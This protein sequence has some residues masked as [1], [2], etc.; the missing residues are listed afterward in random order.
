MIDKFA[1][2]LKINWLFGISFRFLLALHNHYQKP[3]RAGGFLLVIES[4][5][6]ATSYAAAAGTGSLQG[7]S[8]TEVS[9]FSPVR[10]SFF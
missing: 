7:L 9:P 10:A 5:L 8:E 6:E 2:S 4:E 1:L 3:P